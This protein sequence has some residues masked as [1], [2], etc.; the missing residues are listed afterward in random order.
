MAEEISAMELAQK[1]G[2]EVIKNRLRAMAIKN[3][4]VEK[5]VFTET[6]YRVA[7][8]MLSQDKAESFIKEL[9]DLDPNH[10]ISINGDAE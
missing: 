4:L 8:E 9:L 3:L 1:L 5:G 2:S 10:K 7:F 6:E